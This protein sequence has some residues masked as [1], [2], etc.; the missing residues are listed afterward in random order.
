M[1][2]IIEAPRHKPKIPPTVATNQMTITTS[3]RQKISKFSISVQHTEKIVPS[4]ENGLFVRYA[5]IANKSNRKSCFI[6]Q[7]Y[8]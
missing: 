1:K 2:L 5:G 4:H 7:I 3:L 8:I 6:I